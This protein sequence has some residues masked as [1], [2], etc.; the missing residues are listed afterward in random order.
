M[1][2]NQT[3]NYQLSQWVKS[4]QVRMED[5]NADNAKL[6]SALAAQAGTLSGLSASISA[7]QSAV[8]GKQDSAAAVKI[9]VGSY[10][11]NDAAVRTIPVGFTPRA[12]LVMNAQGQAGIYT[13]AGNYAYGGLAVTGAP[14][15]LGGSPQKTCVEVV[16]GGFRV[17]QKVFDNTNASNC[18]KNG[19]GYR[20]LAIG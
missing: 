1:P 9:A 4:D 6:D 17:C 5:F 13:G 16:S 8:S 19:D 14:V 12:V 15:V 18:N 11:G 2:S 10:T 7:L 20:Y 3:T